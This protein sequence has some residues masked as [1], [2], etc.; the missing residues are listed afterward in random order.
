MGDGRDC[1][2]DMIEENDDPPDLTLLCAV[3]TDGSELAEEVVDMMVPGVPPVDDAGDVTV[4]PSNMRL[5]AGNAGGSFSLLVEWGVGVGV[6][7][8]PCNDVPEDVD[9]FTGA[10]SSA[11]GSPNLMVKVKVDPFPGTLL[12][13]ILPPC[14]STNCMDIANPSPV[15]LVCLLILSI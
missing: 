8:S 2:S 1:I 10:L 4:S 15:P 14:N 5:C 11:V 9:G 13:L 3:R 7:V 12:A 6:G